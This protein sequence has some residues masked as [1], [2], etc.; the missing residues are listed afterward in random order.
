MELTKDEA[1]M[2]F[3][4]VNDE[5]KSSVDGFDLEGNRLGKKR[6]YYGRYAKSILEKWFEGQPNIDKSEWIK[7]I[8]FG[9][10]C[11][12]EVVDCSFLLD[13]EEQKFTRKVFTKTK[14]L[15][16]DEPE[17]MND[18]KETDIILYLFREQFH[19]A[20]AVV[21]SILEKI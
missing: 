2:F 21:N 5:Y 16:L 9:I 8:D 7:D 10:R 12:D 19:H 6:I 4:A 20:Y 1:Q 14:K 15:F 3:I 11:L 13:K 17:M 18:E